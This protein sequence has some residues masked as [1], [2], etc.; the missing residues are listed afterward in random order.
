[1][2]RIL[3]A[4]AVL[5]SLVACNPIEG[6]GPGTPPDPTKFLQ[7]DRAGRGVV[8]TLIAAYP[9]TDYQFNYDGYRNGQLQVTVPVGWLVTVQCSNR[10]T[11]KNSC[12]V[13]KDRSSGPVDPAWTTP[14]PANGL[15][16]GASASYSFTPSATGSYRI[17]SLVQGHEA[18]GMWM[19]LE[20]VA[21]G[22]P[23]IGL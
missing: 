6:T 20:V 19:R 7:V 8:L 2:R 5:L 18:S 10:G 22:E 15:A 23:S 3:P 1:M 13:V 9:V 4:V 17:A 11:V 16:A 14:D 21:G 12:A